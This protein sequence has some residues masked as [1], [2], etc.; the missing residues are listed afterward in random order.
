[1]GESAGVRPKLERGAEGKKPQQQQR[2]R[3]TA[4]T[5]KKF[6]APTPGLEH[7]IFKLGDAADAAVF[8]DVKKALAKFAGV[9][10]KHGSNMA[11]IAIVVIHRKYCPSQQGFSCES[12][13]LSCDYQDS[14][15]SQWDYNHSYPTNV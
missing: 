8:T 12:F 15:V 11:Q 1:M 5:D 10:F 3:R 13:S 7:M 2:R 6:K 14:Q 9:N 4:A